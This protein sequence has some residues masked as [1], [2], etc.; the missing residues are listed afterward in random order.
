[1][2]SELGITHVFR[3]DTGV[4]NCVASNGYGHDEMSIHLIVQGNIIDN[5]TDIFSI[6]FPPIHHRVSTYVFPTETPE[7]PRNIRAIDQQS[8]SLQLSWN[9]PYAGNSPIT[10]YVIQYKL[11]SGKY[12]DGG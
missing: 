9:Q 12:N 2:V 11:V 6:C 10:S 5:C 7:I 4:F 3:Q 1:M 8:R